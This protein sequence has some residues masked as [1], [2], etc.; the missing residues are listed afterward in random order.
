MTR[1]DGTQ[2]MRPW[3]YVGDP[4]PPPVPVCRGVPV[5]I[6]R[7]EV[8]SIIGDVPITKHLVGITATCTTRCDATSGRLLVEYRY[9]DGSTDQ[10]T[11]EW[12]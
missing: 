6:C 3:S 4:G 1:P 12:E 8:N 5:E 11:S 2:V 10:V 7:R 9:G